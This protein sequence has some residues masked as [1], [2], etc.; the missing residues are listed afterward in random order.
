[1][2]FEFMWGRDGKA[3]IWIFSFFWFGIQLSL[4]NKLGKLRGD[5]IRA[6][7]PEEN[8]IGE[9]HDRDSEGL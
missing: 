6:R 2:P 1:M 5:M 7:L 9:I 3:G 8:F 4:R